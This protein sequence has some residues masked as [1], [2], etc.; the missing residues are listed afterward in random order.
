M[1]YALVS[2]AIAM[3]CAI[4]SLFFFDFWS[5]TKD[6]LF[7]MFSLAFGILAM[8]RIIPTVTSIANEHSILQ[9]LVRLTAF[10]IILIAIIDKNFKNSGTKNSGS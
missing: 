6:R 7:C 3:G 8:E 4:I 5:T 2:G 10:V 9:Y 1:T